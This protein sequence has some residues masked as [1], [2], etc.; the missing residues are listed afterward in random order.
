MTGVPAIPPDMV[1]QLTPDQRAKLQAS[2]QAY[3]AQGP[4]TVTTRTCLT[5]EKLKEPLDLTQKG[6]DCTHTV[7]SSNSKKQEID[8]K[9][10]I[11]GG[12][13]TGVL[14]MEAVSS[15]H[16]KGTMQ[17]T[18]VADGQTSHSETDIDSKWL[19]GTCSAKDER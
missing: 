12:Q 4:R 5:E 11:G 3:A 18:M 2:L 10:T 9:C 16:V 14:R 17:I 7:V 15:D 13:Q 8:F 19:Q 1:S 6:K